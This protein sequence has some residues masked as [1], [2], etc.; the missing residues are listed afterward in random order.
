[1][2]PFW[3]V[4]CAGQ[5]ALFGLLWAVTGVVIGAMTLFSIHEILH[6]KL[7]KPWLMFMHT[8]PPPKEEPLS[9]SLS[10]RERI[11]KIIAVIKWILIVVSVIA[12]IFMTFWMIGRSMAWLFNKEVCSIW[13]K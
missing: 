12:G 4:E 9:P 11:V 2:N 10:W 6:E 13:S 7:G 5:V 3:T 1:M 8:N